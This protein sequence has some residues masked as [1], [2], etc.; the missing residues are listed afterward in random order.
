MNTIRDRKQTPFEQQAHS[1]CTGAFATSA[2]KNGSRIFV[3]H[4]DGRVRC[5][6]D[7]GTVDVI[8]AHRGAILSLELD[9]SSESLISGGDDGKFLEIDPDRGTSAEI[10]NFGSRWVDHV[11]ANRNGLRACATGRSVHIWRPGASKADILEHPSSI[12]G[13][14]F[15]PTGNRL[16]VAH[17]GGATIWK[18][19]AKRGW[20]RTLLRWAG[21]HIG[22][23]WSPNG[24][25]LVSS[26]QESALHGWRLRDQSDMQMSGYP[27]KVHAWDWCGDEPFL[28]TSGAA[29]AVCWPFDGARG[30]MGR[31][32][33]TRGGSENSWVTQVCTLPGTRAFLAGFENGSV[34][35]CDLDEDGP[36]H[37]LRHATGAEVTVLTATDGLEM[38][39][40]GDAEGQ[41]LW[42]RLARES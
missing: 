2:V 16:A 24:Q 1:L 30:P 12:G 7:D 40:I 33:L 38:L 11:A 17:Y 6:N 35:L 34:M 25:Y 22:V 9:P 3:A 15:G 5:L 39:A 14:A 21:S 20:Q 37:I 32:P 31:S 8:E 10:A 27:T 29:Q 36:A 18:R 26:M 41:V 23:T 28:I 42:S 13:I 4:G 19:Q